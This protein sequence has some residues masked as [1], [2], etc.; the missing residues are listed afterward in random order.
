MCHVHIVH[1]I[2]QCV[3]REAQIKHEQLESAQRFTGPNRNRN[4]GESGRF[5]F[6]ISE[7][8]IGTAGFKL[9]KLF[10]YFFI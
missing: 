10:Y 3:I 2:A 4:R 9:R 5:Q 1:I 7:R 6:K 8:G